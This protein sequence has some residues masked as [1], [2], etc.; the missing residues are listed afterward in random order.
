MSVNPEHV[1]NVALIHELQTAS[2]I[3]GHG[4]RITAG[5]RSEVQDV[6]AALHCLAFG[7]EKLLKLT[8]VFAKKDATGVVPR[9]TELRTKFRHGVVDLEGH[10]RGEIRRCCVGVGGEG[11]LAQ[12]LSAVD[13]D[14]VVPAVLRALGDWGAGGRY[15]Y[16]SV[17]THPAPAIEQLWVDPRALWR[18]VEDAVALPVETLMSPNVRGALNRAIADS[19]QRWWELYFRAW[20]HGLVGAEARQLASVNDPSPAWS[21]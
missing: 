17:Y 14:P 5:L 20:Q 11:Y 9:D 4:L 7:A 18:E 15:S 12:L 6:P 21:R 8:Y 10:T 16:M 19:V 1:R 2:S 3:L 13:A